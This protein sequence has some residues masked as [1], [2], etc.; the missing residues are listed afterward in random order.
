MHLL[1]G[2][3]SEVLIKVQT[4]SELHGSSQT[5]SAT[6]LTSHPNPSNEK[7]QLR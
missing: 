5:P 6:T 2:F 1:P 3:V 4:C 7:F